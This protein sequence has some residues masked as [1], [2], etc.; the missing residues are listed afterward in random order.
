MLS[1]SFESRLYST[2]CHKPTLLPHSKFC[3]VQVKLVPLYFWNLQ[4]R[5][6]ATPSTV[7]W[8]GEGRTSKF[9]VSLVCH[10]SSAC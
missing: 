6:L 3:P 4:P 9:Q 1:I 2:T 8:W 5:I 10:D 7:P